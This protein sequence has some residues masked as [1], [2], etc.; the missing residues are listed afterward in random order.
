ME[1]LNDE[2]G[3]KQLASQLIHENILLRAQFTG[4]KTLL[5]MLLLKDSPNR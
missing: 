5:G 4:L 3:I 2:D 1:K